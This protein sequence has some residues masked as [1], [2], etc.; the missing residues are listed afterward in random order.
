MGK[1]AVRC[2]VLQQWILIS[3]K[4]S[5]QSGTCQPDMQRRRLPPWDSGS[6]ETLW[7]R[8]ARGFLALP[9]QLLKMPQQE[10]DERLL[11]YTRGGFSPPQSMLPHANPQERQ[12]QI[13][14]RQPFHPLSPFL[15]LT[16]SLKCRAP[17]R[18]Q[19]RL[20]DP[21]RIYLLSCFPAQGCLPRAVDL[22][23]NRGKASGCGP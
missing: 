4:D 7:A 18:C 16:A 10:Q 15:R 5:M 2:L 12:P 20:L 17:L 23:A 21:I 14:E 6:P 9:T 3:E 8:G 13:Q 11:T 19:V 1:E 22:G